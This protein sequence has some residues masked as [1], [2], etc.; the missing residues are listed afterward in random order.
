VQDSK[1]AKILKE[2]FFLLQTYHKACNWA[3]QPNKRRKSMRYSKGLHQPT[4]CNT[5]R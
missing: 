2:T 3:A 1:T 5:V 4:K